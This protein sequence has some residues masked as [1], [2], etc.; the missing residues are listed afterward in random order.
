MRIGVVGSGIA[1]PAAA[2]VLSEQHQVTV[3]EAND[4]VSGHVYV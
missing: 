4:Y 2:R 3:F 1:V